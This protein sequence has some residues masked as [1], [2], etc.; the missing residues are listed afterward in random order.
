[1]PNLPIENKFMLPKYYQVFES[2]TGF[3]P[4][5]SI[6]DLLFAEGNNAMSFI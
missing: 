2:K 3:L 4:N 6:I 1:K 5:M